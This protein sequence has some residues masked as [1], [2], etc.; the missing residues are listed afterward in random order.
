MSFLTQR[1][2]NTFPLRSTVR[3]DQSSVGQ[4]L[5]SCFSDLAE[6][7]M[8][9]II[10][11]T[12]SFTLDKEE[13]HVGAVYK[14][15]L[16]EE[17]SFRQDEYNEMLFEFPVV[18][19]ILEDDTKVSIRKVENSESFMYGIPTRI[20]KINTISCSGHG[21]FSNQSGRDVL[22]KEDLP[23]FERLVVDVRESTLYKNQSR[24]LLQ[25]PFN[26]MSFVKL[27]GKDK[28]LNDIEE[29]IAVTSDGEYKTKKVFRRLDKVEYDGFDGFI[30][31]RVS[32][33]RYKDILKVRK[34][35]RFKTVTNVLRSGLCE[36][37]VSKENIEFES[38]TETVWYLDIYARFIIDES[39]VKNGKEFE[40]ELIRSKIA[41][42]ILLDLDYSFIEPVDFF[43]SEI[44]SRV[45]VL[46]SLNRVHIYNLN[47]SPFL[48]KG[49]KRT[50]GVPIVS[51]LLTQRAPYGKD[52]RVQ[53]ELKNNVGVVESWEI[54][55]VSPEGN[56]YFLKYEHNPNLM[57][58]SLK[59]LDA[60]ALGI[61]SFLNSP[62]VDGARLASGIA[63]LSW[64]DFG[65]KINCDE[66]GQWDLYTKVKYVDG[67]EFLH[68]TSFM[69][70]YLIPLNTFEVEDKSRGI[71]LNESNNLCV[72]AIG[73]IVEYQQK[74]DCYLADV[75]SNRIILRDNYKEV[76]VTYE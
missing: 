13:V 59:W 43:I 53:C 25:R 48:E 64:R 71:F 9:D 60:N 61:S 54:K 52:V 39:M 3:V 26:G 8:V 70:E 1:F 51:K 75:S 46:D 68:K 65:Y 40:E 12:S 38:G 2:A 66:I 4:K 74:Y 17:D 76:E 14:I 57:S 44:D 28:F 11:M 50:A 47:L 22:I 6:S 5:F 20:E 33:A 35:N 41:G 32:E 62:L 34:R 16:T 24:P 73:K 30:E 67:N 23:F 36:L 21:V 63:E 29:Y 56:V 58:T 10:K 19:G 7:T 49:E 69:C 45:Y 55:A 37:Q 27:R 72:R 31:I 42:I 15:N 18:T